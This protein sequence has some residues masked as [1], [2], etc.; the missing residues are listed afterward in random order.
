MCRRIVPVGKGSVHL[1][2]EYVPVAEM[3]IGSK[4]YS[5][6]IAFVVYGAI[7]AGPLHG[8]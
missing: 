2:P 5:I 1:I 6:H 3:Q 7:A 8:L 4:K